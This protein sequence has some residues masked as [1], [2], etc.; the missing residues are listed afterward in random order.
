MLLFAQ[1]L[2][3]AANGPEQLVNGLPS[4]TAE[5]F[6]SPLQKIRE[7]FG[8]VR[9]D[10]NISTKDTFT[11]AATGDDGYNL[12]PLINPLFG[13]V[14][15]LRSQ[16]DSLQETHALFPATHQHGPGGILARGILVRFARPGS[17]SCA[18]P[19]ALCGQT[20]W[21]H[22]HRGRLRCRSE[23]IHSGW[24]RH[25]RKYLEQ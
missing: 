4:G 21:A 23:F 19:Y 18:E 15:R 7:D 5:N 11:A 6:N 14:A 13:T 20:V 9:F 3:P 2:W 22:C 8:T 16:V 25:F 10:E 24:R 12:S 1:R 17:Y